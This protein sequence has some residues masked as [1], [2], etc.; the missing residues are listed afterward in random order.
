LPPENSNSTEYGLAIGGI[1][2]LSEAGVQAGSH[3]RFQRGYASGDAGIISASHRARLVSARAGFSDSDA[4][5][6][7][8]R[9]RDRAAALN[10][11]RQITMEVITQKETS[12]VAMH[13]AQHKM[14]LGSGARTA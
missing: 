4:N 14:C 13:F 7:S 2:E 1:T 9:G 10:R 6:S 5:C 8:M 11:D 3:E 12:N